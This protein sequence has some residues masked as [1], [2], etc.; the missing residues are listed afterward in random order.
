MKLTL[1]NLH[2]Q[3]ST[4]LKLLVERH[5]EKLGTSVQIDEARVVVEN[6]S[7]ASPPFHMS[8]HLV[9]PGPDIF[10]EAR[11]HTLR[12]ALTK[13]FEDLEDEVARRQLKRTLRMRASTK[14]KPAGSLT[15]LGSRK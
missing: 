12:A 11:D 13:I 8:V 7:E 2:H 5:L 9:T 1:K 3:P 15:A 6:R 10:A 4:S 14:K